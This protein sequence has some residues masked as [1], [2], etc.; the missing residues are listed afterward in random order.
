MR[1]PIIVAGFDLPVSM[2]P[3]EGFLHER[4]EVDTLGIDKPESEC[5]FQ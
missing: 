5:K 2:S 3:Q 1:Q 4:A